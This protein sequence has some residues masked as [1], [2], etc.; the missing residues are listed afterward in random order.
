MSAARQLV[1]PGLVV[2]H[3]I[4]LAAAVTMVSLGRWQLDR[5]AEVRGLIERQEAQLEAVPA[6]LT[7]VPDPTGADEEA[8]ETLEFTRVEAV[9]VYRPEEEVLHRGRSLGG[10]SGYHVLT[11]LDLGDGTS[12]LVRRGWVPFELDTPPVAGAAPPGGE[13]TVTGW[14]ERP[15]TQPDGFGQ[16][17]PEDGRL[18]RVFHAD[19]ARL[20]GQVTGTLRTMVLHLE[21][22]DPPAAGELPVPVPRPEFSATTHLSYAVQWFSFATIALVAY[23]FWLRRRLRRGPGRDAERDVDAVGPA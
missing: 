14:L 10:R 13:V 6:P 19:T 3:V 7:S 21:D 17:D 20:D 22:Q 2:S 12:V 15:G 1:R 18:E 8:T 16:R 5:H 23:G 11:P 9:G 4:V